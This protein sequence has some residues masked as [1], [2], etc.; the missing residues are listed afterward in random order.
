MKIKVANLGPIRQAEFEMG[1]LTTISGKNNTGKTYIT[2]AMFGFL[3]Y[4]HHGY[5]VPFSNT[6]FG[7][8]HTDGKLTI[9]LESYHKKRNSYVTTASKEYSKVISQIFA[10]RESAFKDTEVKVTSIGKNTS[11][12]A[13]KFKANLGTKDRPIVGLEKKS[14][15]M[16]LVVSLLIDLD[17]E[18]S[19]PLDFSK[20]MIVDAIKDLVF[21]NLIPNPFVSSAERTGA[22][23]FQKELDF[24]RNRLVEILGDKSTKLRPF[25]LLSQFK[26]K[27]PVAVRRNVDFIRDLSS[28]VDRESFILKE[29]PELLDQFKDIIGGTY[30]VNKEGDV[31]YLPTSSKGRTKLSLV[32]SSSSVRSLLDI[33]FYLRHIVKKGDLLVVDEPELNLHPENQRR[34][35]RL[36]A[37][38]V[39]L[40]VRVFV[41]THSDYIIKEFNTLLMLN[42]DSR[43]LGP[44][45]EREKYS[46]IER[47]NAEEVRSYVAAESVIQLDGNTR[48]SRCLTLVPAEISQSL[49]IEIQSFDETINEM[50]RI[51]EEIVWGGENA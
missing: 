40:G 49:G 31:Q 44:I 18:E 45:R 32:E 46:E 29:H 8:L 27:Y 43:H 30:A 11:L 2:H 3:D 47:L 42:Q 5:S 13:R 15:S 33:G 9:D 6:E 36:F 24:T 10:A 7:K 50:N 14:G 21:E 38:L 34:I 28:I 1:D 22:A 37:S 4:F 25:D 19:A 41:T 48:K 39:R 12:L 20:H 17:D 51:Q 23:I 35:A 16:A 26:G